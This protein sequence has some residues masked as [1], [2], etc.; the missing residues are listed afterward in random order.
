MKVSLNLS[1]QG[2]IKLKNKSDEKLFT[3]SSRIAQRR[4]K[5]F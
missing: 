2:I 4:S 3:V 1:Q 5:Y